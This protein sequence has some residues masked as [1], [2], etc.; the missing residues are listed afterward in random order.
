MLKYITDKLGFLN[1]KKNTKKEL[2]IEDLN[3]VEFFKDYIKDTSISNTNIDNN[4]TTNCIFCLGP[5]VAVHYDVFNPHKQEVEKVK[6]YQC[7]DFKNCR[8]N[9]VLY[10]E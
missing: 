1:I 2:T 7:T 4:D 10:E 9:F 5:A 3:E 6:A 8:C